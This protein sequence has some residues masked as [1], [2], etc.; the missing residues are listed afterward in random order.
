[1]QHSSIPGSV[2]GVCYI[3]YLNG[4]GGGGVKRLELGFSLK[5]ER[6]WIQGKDQIF[7]FCPFEI[8]QQALFSTTR[9]FFEVPFQ[10]QEPQG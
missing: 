4:G 3:S 5:L 6:E 10:S 9:Q 8:A 7:I 1:M 2:R